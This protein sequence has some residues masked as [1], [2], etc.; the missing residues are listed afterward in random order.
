M[1]SKVIAIVGGSGAGKT[2]L[3]NKLTTEF[4]DS[5]S[6]VRLDN[7][8]KD[9]SHLDFTEREKTNFDEPS[10]IDWTEFKSVFE[11]IISGKDA[12]LPVYDFCSHT[13]KPERLLFRAT[14]VVIVEG[15][16]LIHEA[17]LRKLFSF[18][19]FVESSEKLRLER[20]IARDVNER[21]RTRESV[22]SQF[23][24]HVSPMHDKFV[25]PQKQFAD[26]VLHSP[27][28]QAEWK[29]LIDRIKNKLNLR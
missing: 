4:G 3:A 15:L 7:F 27:W 18:S 21:G 23:K 6:I 20:R 8:Y 1:L 13:R 24:K 19:I 29:C 9:L 25:E 12:Y 17:W 28:S 16:W 2:F 10:A 11:T 5:A 14:P 22:I 26:F